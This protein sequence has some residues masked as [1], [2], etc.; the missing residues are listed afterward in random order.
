MFVLLFPFLESK[1]E[2]VFHKYAHFQKKYLLNVMLI[3][4][5]ILT[6]TQA[7]FLN[8]ERERERERKKTQAPLPH[9]STHGTH[10]ASNS[11]SS[12]E[13]KHGL[14]EGNCNITGSCMLFWHRPFG[15]LPFSKSL[16]LATA[17]LQPCKSTPANLAKCAVGVDSVFHS[18][19]LE[20]KASTTKIFH[21]AT[22]PVTYQAP[23]NNSENI[24]RRDQTDEITWSKYK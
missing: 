10:K 12:P 9:T 5:P 1:C 21:R 18:T 19:K 17:C 8:R 15:Y 20:V 22:L 13:N 3:F 11:M 14:I 7:P 4:R 6:T 16:Q 2:N 24:H 23:P